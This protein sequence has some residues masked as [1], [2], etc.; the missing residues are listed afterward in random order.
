M[1][2]SQC[3][4]P[5]PFS[6]CVAAHAW[7]D[8]MRRMPGANMSDLFQIVLAWT[9]QASLTCKLGDSIGVCAFTGGRVAGL[10]LGGDFCKERGT[11]G[12]AQEDRQLPLRRLT[13]DQTRQTRPLPWPERTPG[14][15][16]RLR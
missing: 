10:L 4:G 11:P 7:G 8:V 9:I 2:F 13:P 12:S 1:L 6:P 16:Y 5:F 3:Q 15:V 14:T